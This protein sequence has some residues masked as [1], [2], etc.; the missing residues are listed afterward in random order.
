MAQATESSSTTDRELRTGRILAASRARVFECFSDPKRLARW[1][2]PKGFRNTFEEFEFRTDGNW[3]FVMH[4]P[5]GV[6]FPNRA[7]FTQITKPERIVIDHVSDPHFRL[8]ITLEDEGGKTLLTWRQTFDSVRECEKLRKVCVEANEEN[9]DR[10][11]A[12]LARMV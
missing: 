12:E 6:D 11:A 1:W 10:L 8:T 2:G 5:K 4:S 3:S 7:V 9:L